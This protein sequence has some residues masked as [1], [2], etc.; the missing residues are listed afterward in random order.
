MQVEIVPFPMPIFPF[1]SWMLVPTSNLKFGMDLNE[2]RRQTLCA[3]AFRRRR[4]DSK[5]LVYSHCVRINS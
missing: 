3:Q 4:T 2:V 5:W 1:K